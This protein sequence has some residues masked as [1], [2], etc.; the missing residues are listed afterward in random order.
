MSNYHLE[1]ENIS[2]GKGQSVAN[3]L[4]YISGHELKDSYG[5]CF[6]HNRED[7]RY[8]KIFLPPN[9]PPEYHDLQ[10]LCDAINNAEKRRDARTAR[11]FIGSLPNELPLNEHIQIVREYVE[12]NFVSQGLCAVVA[13]HEG[14]NRDDPAKNNPHVHVIV[15]TRAVG[16]DGFNMKKDREH[17]KNNYI[18][19]WRKS[20][21]DVQ[22][23]AYERNGLEIRVS[24]ESLEVQGI[25]R[26]AI[27]H[28]TRTDYEKERRGERTL[29][30]DKRRE[31]ER[32]NAERNRQRQ[33]KRRYAR[34]IEFSR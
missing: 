8:Y 25:R 17:N 28:L 9:A 24:H 10:Y 30:G 29:A 16:P 27:P 6:C 18:R 2:R 13:I 12:K 3:S 1:V 34:E 33:M 21:A 32:R 20:W 4:S 7:V 22:N 11:V 15:T 26:E 23:R 19:L 14:Q 5:K 31:I